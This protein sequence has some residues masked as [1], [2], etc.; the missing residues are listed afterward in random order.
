MIAQGLER[1]YY[2]LTIYGPMSGA[3]ALLYPSFVNDDSS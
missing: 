3:I 1:R 2:K